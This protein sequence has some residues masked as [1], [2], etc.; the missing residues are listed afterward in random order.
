MTT[1]GTYLA[2]LLLAIP[3]LCAVAVVLVVVIGALDR[4]TPPV[5]LPRTI[6]SIPTSP[7]RPA[8]PPAGFLD[9]DVTHV[10]EGGVFVR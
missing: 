5:K 3:V 10:F 1:L 8:L 9:D 7:S 2:L 4:R 6:A